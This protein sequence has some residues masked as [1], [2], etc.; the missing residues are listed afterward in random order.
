ML[1]GVETK[2]ILISKHDLI[3]DSGD[4]IQKSTLLIIQ[5]IKG[6]TF[7]IFKHVEKPSAPIVR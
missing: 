1:Y 5:I 7:S 6:C 2:N 3:V 4:G